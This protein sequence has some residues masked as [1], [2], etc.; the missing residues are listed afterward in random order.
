MTMRRKA[1]WYWAMIDGEWA[2]L[3][4]DGG[5]WLYIGTRQNAVTEVG[6]RI[7][8]PDEPW[9]LVPVEP[10]PDMLFALDAGRAAY[11]SMRGGYQAMLEAAKREEECPDGT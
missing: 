7:P 2:P 1:G 5:R 6:H 9:Q 4:W 10:T 3:Y 8:T 11:G